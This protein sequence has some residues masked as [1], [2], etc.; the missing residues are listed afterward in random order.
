[1]EGRVP[2]IDGRVVAAEGDLEVIV[3][4]VADDEPLDFDIEAGDGRRPRARIGA[5]R[6]AQFAEDTHLGR[7]RRTHMQRELAFLKPRMWSQQGLR[8]ETARG[9]MQIRR[10]EVEIAEARH[11]ERGIFGPVRIGNGRRIVLVRGLHCLR[12]SGSRSRSGSC[13]RDRPCGGVLQ[14]R[15]TLFQSVDSRQQPFDEFP[16]GR[17]RS[18]GACPVRQCQKQ[19]HRELSSAH[20]PPQGFTK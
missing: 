16:G 4:V 2:V 18:L 20:N 5:R 1:M 14:L 7:K 12:R 8:A 13:G 9:P 19:A 3:Q 15:D 6:H 11:L 10:R 17:I